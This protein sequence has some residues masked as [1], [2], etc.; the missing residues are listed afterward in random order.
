MC[1]Q[2]RGWGAWGG[3]GG[4]GSCRKAIERQLKRIEK[5]MVD[6]KK[7]KGR[8]VYSVART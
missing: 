8:G 1:R 6:E 3:G 4:N 7:K 5:A 2:H